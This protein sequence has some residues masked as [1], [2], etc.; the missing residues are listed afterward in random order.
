[1]TKI[2]VI[3][4]KNTAEWDS[5]LS[6]VGEYDTYHCADY[7]LLAESLGEGTPVLLA[8]NEGDRCAALPLLLRNIPS[9]KSLIG[10]PWRDATSVYG[11]PGVITSCSSEDPQFAASF[12]W[13]LR[14]K[15][16]ELNVVSVFSRL[17]P[18]IDTSWLLRGMAQIANHGDTIWINLTETE[19]DQMASTRTDHRRHLRHAA[20]VGMNFRNDP[21]FLGMDDFKA[22]YFETMKRNN[23]SPYYYFSDL[24]FET[25]RTR[26]ASTT[27][28]F[29][30]ELNGRPVSAT[31]I[32]IT[33]KYLQYHLN[34][35]PTEYMNLGCSRYILNEIRKWGKR[36]GY[37]WMNLGGGVSS[38]VDS[39]F[40]FKSGF[41]KI[42]RPFQ[43]VR[44]I[45][46]SDVYADLSRAH[47]SRRGECAV[48]YFPEYRR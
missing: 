38:Q 11:Y 29:F 37:N 23:A 17:H 21:E 4:A 45:L 7:H 44:M 24:Y 22:M 48:E 10:S 13:A 42:R 30:A 47:E 32:F 9:A 26:L 20:K 33:G 41:S 12:Q 19:E 36:N 46:N 3:E 8:Y 15:L 39:L 28:L 31:I 27:R 5:V 35:T 34:G 18:V 43:S 6:Q 40:Q 14:E 16:N 25:L 2:K 1:M